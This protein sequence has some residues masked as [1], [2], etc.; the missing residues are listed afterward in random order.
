ML[1]LLT[2]RGPGRPGDHS[3]LGFACP[4]KYDGKRHFA[5]LSDEPIGCPTCLAEAKR[6]ADTPVGRAMIKGGHKLSA[7]GLAEVD[8][9]SRNMGWRV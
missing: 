7:M 5:A 6:L 2:Y 1:H 9:L 4:A 3:R 8:H